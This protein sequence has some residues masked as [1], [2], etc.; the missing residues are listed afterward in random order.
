MQSFHFREE[1]EKIAGDEA[2]TFTGD[3]A[4]TVK[5]AV[6]AAIPKCGGGGRAA[7]VLSAIRKN[8]KGAA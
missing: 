7:A 5:G 4:D 3:S 2:H 1:L 6:L 8:K